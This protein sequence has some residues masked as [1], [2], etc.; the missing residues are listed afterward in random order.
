M[1][2]QRRGIGAREQRTEEIIN[3]QLHVGFWRG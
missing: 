3:C 2:G 1:R